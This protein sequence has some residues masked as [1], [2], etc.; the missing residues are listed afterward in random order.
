MC[1]VCFGGIDDLKKHT[2][3]SKGCIVNKTKF[4]IPKNV[5]RVPFLSILNSGSQRA[6]SRADE[7]LLAKLIFVIQRCPALSLLLR[8]PLCRPHK[9]AKRQYLQLLNCD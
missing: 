7:E 1:T 3:L 6:V 9:P 8:E 2:I 4:E 5:A